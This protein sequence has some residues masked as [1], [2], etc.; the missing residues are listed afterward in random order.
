MNR[1]IPVAIGLLVAVSVFASDKFNTDHEQFSIATTGRI[2]RINAKTRIMTIRNSDAAPAPPAANG[3]LLKLPRIVFPGGIGITLPTSFSKPTAGC[4][5]EYTV[6]TTDETVFQDGADPI[7][8]D[9]FKSGETVSIHG[10]FNGT[11]LT[12]SRVAKWS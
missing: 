2:V 10:V 11:V 4:L 5:H 8:F 6:V 12:A 1:F 7:R 9:D 3:P